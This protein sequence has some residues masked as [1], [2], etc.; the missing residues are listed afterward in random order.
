MKKICVAFI[1]ALVFLGCFCSCGEKPQPN[2][3]SSYVDIDQFEDDGEN[4]IPSTPDAS[5][6][7]PSEW[8][9]K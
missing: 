9:D 8:G 7:M 4:I 6:T 1:L 5:V 2:K 3:T